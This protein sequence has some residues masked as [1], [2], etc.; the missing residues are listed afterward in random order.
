MV[1]GSSELQNLQKK[2][3][4]D[5]GIQWM[6]IGT[7]LFGSEL[8]IAR[9]SYLGPIFCL[10]GMEAHRK[11]SRACFYYWMSPQH[12]SGVWKYEFATIC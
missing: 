6:I 12:C 1:N 11:Y 5:G 2:Q 8:S 3:M 7:K 9:L 4:S 10:T